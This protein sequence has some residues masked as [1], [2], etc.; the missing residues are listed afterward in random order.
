MGLKP[1]TLHHGKNINL[2]SEQSAEKN[3]WTKEGAIDRMF[4][5]TAG[6]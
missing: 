6:I 2:V 5:K 4:E 1:D 3:I